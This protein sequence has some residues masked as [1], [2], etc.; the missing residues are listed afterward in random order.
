MSKKIFILFSI[1][2]FIILLVLYFACNSFNSFLVVGSISLAQLF[3]ISYDYGGFEFK[4]IWSQFLIVVLVVFT[5]YFSYLAAE[6]DPSISFTISQHGLSS[7]SNK[8]NDNTVIYNPHGSSLKG[9]FYS[10]CPYK[11][12]RW[13]DRSNIPPIGF[14]KSSSNIFVPDLNSPCPIGDDI[15]ANSCDFLASTRKQDFLDMGS[16]LSNGH[17]TGVTIT[18]ISPCPG[19]DMFQINRFKK[20]GLG[21]VICATCS[22]YL[23]HYHGFQ[24]GEDCPD[25]KS[26]SLCG[27]CKEPSLLQSTFQ[28]RATAVILISYTSFC[29]L[30]LILY[31]FNAVLKDRNNRVKDI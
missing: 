15:D 11:G 16:G 4:M 29:Q 5:L 14:N 10:F 23:F 24:E 18:N 8:V 3:V 7:C 28:L 9:P 22:R 2:V 12:S 30:C 21:N 13:G 19:V 1:T 6:G 20:D 31:F 25:S 26:T 17:T 27:L